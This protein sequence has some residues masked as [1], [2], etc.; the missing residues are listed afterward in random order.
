[1]A[2][3]SNPVIFSH[4]HSSLKRSRGINKNVLSLHDEGIAKIVKHNKLL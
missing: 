2:I 1:M 3:S 4:V